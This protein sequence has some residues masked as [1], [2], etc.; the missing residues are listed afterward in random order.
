[1]TLHQ[2]KVF[3]AVAKLGSFTKAAKILRVSQP[4]VTLVVQGLGREL[5]VKLF[6]KLG[7]KIRLTA[8]G[9]SLFHR[10]EDVLVKVEGIKEEMDEIKGLKKGKLRVGGA[11][12][13]GVSFLPAIA[14]MFGEKHRDVD[15]ILKVH[16][17]NAV[18]K[19]LL[20]GELDVGLLARLPRSSH[21]IAEPYRDEEIV[22]IAPPGHPLT[23]K[24][25]VPLEVVAH[26]PLIIQQR[27]DVLRE[28]LERRFADIGLH[29]QA[30]LEVDTPFGIRDA[31]KS[32]VAC[33]F[34]LG[35]M[36]RCHIA[37]DLKAGRLAVIKVPDLNLK[38]SMYIAVHKMREVSPLVQEFIDLLRRY[39]DKEMP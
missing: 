4:S 21:L 9:E 33:G 17:S 30:R 15:V 5:E 27:G 37:V 12:I 19:D 7:N 11:A 28:M 39:K 2:L 18:E 23:K 25:F 1:M 34:G 36:H 16:S 29:L 32:A 24:R 6:E 38:R 26:E 10:A 14:Q 35:C 20:E 31:I 3:A 8:A 13:A 22:V